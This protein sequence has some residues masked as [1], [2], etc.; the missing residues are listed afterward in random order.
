MLEQSLRKLFEQ[1]AE[2]EPPPGR[3]TVADV[4]RQG[5]L[6]RR[7]HRI[8]AAVG[9]PALAAVA[10]AAIALTSV[11][12]SG[13]DHTSPQAGGRGNLVGDA[14][15]PSYLAINFGWLPAG[16]SAGG[17]TTGPGL[18]TLG[19]NGLRK[20]GGPWNLSVYA[21]NM[22]H[23]TKA[24]RQFWCAGAGLAFANTVAGHGPVIDGH[25]SL[26]L[27]GHS[28]GPADYLDLAWESA[29]GAWSIVEQ[30][31]PRRSSGAAM[32]VQIA[33]GVEYGQ[34][35]PIRFTARFTSLPPGWR[36]LGVDF[37]SI[38]GADRS[39]PAGTFFASSY[40][41]SRLRTI[42]PAMALGPLSNPSTDT[43]WI[44]ISPVIP[45]QQVC[46]NPG[47]QAGRVTIHGYGFVL[48]DDQTGTPGHVQSD[49]WLCRPNAD[50]LTVNVDETGAGAHPHLALSPLQIMERTQLLGANPAGWVTNPMP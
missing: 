45:G 31:F 22:C 14:F 25:K 27:R 33:R 42:G 36:I 17:G 47:R 24:G 40:N 8:G 5:R 16:T 18:E 50:G 41:I 30:D 39:L 2:V 29:P 37:S 35:I 1:Q 10:V 26:W 9:A 46:S 20:Y 43:P 13:L 11:L 34:H 48:G 21:R 19:V 32:A 23:V 12:P 28:F 7:R 15:D 3:V 4:L 6:R 38:Y 49:L 44:S